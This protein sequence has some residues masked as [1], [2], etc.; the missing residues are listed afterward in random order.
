MS[1][2]I[3]VINTFTLRDG[4]QD[5]FVRMQA[6]F[7]SRR[8]AGAVPG[9]RASRMYRSVDGSRATLISEFDSVESHKALLASPHFEEHREKLRPYIVRAEPAYYQLAYKR[10][11][12]G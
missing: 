2:P 11:S 5:E 1:E 6:E 12:E 9:F 3:I 8:L 10:R 4:M 7:G